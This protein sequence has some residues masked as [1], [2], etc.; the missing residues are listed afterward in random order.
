MTTA[1]SSTSLRQR[2]GGDFST[3]LSVSDKGIALDELY[4]RIAPV[5]RAIGGKS[6]YGESEVAFE[7]AMVFL[8]RRQ[9]APSLHVEMSS[10]LVADFAPIRPLC[11]DSVLSVQGRRCLRVSRKADWVFSF[12][13]GEWLCVNRPLTEQQIRQCLTLEG[14]LLSL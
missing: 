2:A 3:L 14:A 1:S 9:R 11:A 5:A 7:P 4:G 12:L 13:N 6:Y 8:Q 10:G